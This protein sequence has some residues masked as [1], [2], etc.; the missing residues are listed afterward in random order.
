MSP[1][2]SGEGSVSVLVEVQWW[3]VLYVLKAHQM[4]E[5]FR[6]CLLREAYINCLGGL[7]V[8]VE[9]HAFFNACS[10][11]PEVCGGAC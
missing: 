5:V 9:V 6:R 1:F 4:S 8:Q 7:G 10:L 2:S 11:F 3:V